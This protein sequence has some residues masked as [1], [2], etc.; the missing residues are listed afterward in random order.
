MNIDD[1]WGGCAPPRLGIGYQKM[2]KEMF[3]LFLIPFR[4]V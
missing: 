4:V 2:G 1:E 3:G